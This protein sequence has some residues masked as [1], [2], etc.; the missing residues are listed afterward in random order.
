MLYVRS[1][2]LILLTGESLYLLTN[3]FLLPTTP[4]NQCSSM[5]FYECFMFFLVSIF[6]EY[7]CFFALPKLCTFLFCARFGRKLSWLYSSAR[8]QTDGERERETRLFK[9][10]LCAFSIATVGGTS[11][12]FTF[13]GFMFNVFSC[14]LLPFR[15]ATYHSPNS[16]WSR[17]NW[18]LTINNLGW[19]WN[20][21][22]RCVFIFR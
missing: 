13:F 21:I 1:L 6:Q 17:K 16:L 3:I 10:S 2:E 11:D 4:C 18:W 7:S 14:T 5:C 9:K 20:V 22:I 19:E 15:W 12:I 8:N